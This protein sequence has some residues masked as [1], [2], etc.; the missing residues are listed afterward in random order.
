MWYQILPL[1]ERIVLDAAVGDAIVP[2]S[3]DAQDPALDLSSANLS[4]TPDLLIETESDITYFGQTPLY[5]DATDTFLGINGNEP[6]NPI[7]I[8]GVNPIDG[9]TITILDPEAGDQLVLTNPDLLSIFGITQLPITFSTESQYLGVYESN[10]GLAGTELIGLN[11]YTQTLLLETVSPPPFGIGIDT[12]LNTEIVWTSSTGMNG[13]LIYDITFESATDGTPLSLR[14]ADVVDV[15]GRIYYESTVDGLRHIDFAATDTAG[16]T[17][18]FSLIGIEFQSPNSPPNAQD[19]SLSTGEDLPVAFSAADLLGNDSDP[20]GDD[21][22]IIKLTNN[23]PVGSDPLMPIGGGGDD[24]L[25]LS[26]GGNGFITVNGDGT[27]VYTPFQGF[28]GTDFFVYTVSDGNGGEATATVTVDVAPDDVPAAIDVDTV[29]A[30][31]PVGGNDLVTI[32]LVSGE[33]A[34][35]L[36]NLDLSAED[37][38]KLGILGINNPENVLTIF[39][40]RPQNNIKSITIV[41]PNPEAGDSLGFLDLDLISDTPVENVQGIQ[42]LAQALNAP[43]NLFGSQVNLTES[44]GPQGEIIYT[45]DFTFL[46]AGVPSGP[47]VVTPE[48]ASDILSLVAFTPEANSGGRALEVFVTDD[49]N[50]D[51]EINIINILPP[52]SAPDAQDDQLVLNEDGAASIDLLANDND[53]DLDDLAVT[54]VSGPAN[55]QAVLD[56]MGNLTYTPDAN[57]NGSDQILYEIS[58]GELT[59]QATLAITVNPV[60]DAP[61]AVADA[62]TVSAGLEGS[63]NVLEN[64]VDV[65]LPNDSLVAE[66]VSGPQNGSLVFN[67]DGSFVYQHD[68]SPNMTDSFTYRVVD[69]A[70]ASDEAVVSLTIEEQ[71]DGPKLKL[72]GFDKRLYFENQ[73]AKILS[74][75]VFLRDADS[76]DFD[77]GRLTVDISE[78]GTIND[79]LLI[80]ENNK[81]W[82]DNAGQV[83]YR[84]E[85]IGQVEGGQNGE[86]LIV[87]F[88]ANASAWDVARVISRIAY[89]N[90]SD[91]PDTAVRNIAFTVSDGDGGISNLESKQIWFIDINDDPEILSENDS[92]T[93]EAGELLNIGEELGI[94]VTDADLD[95]DGNVLVTLRVG[96]GLLGFTDVEDLETVVFTDELDSDGMRRITFTANLDEANTLLSRLTYQARDNFTGTDTLFVKVNDLGGDGLLGGTGV[97]WERF[98]IHVC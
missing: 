60:N 6:D 33:E 74:P 56:A 49:D 97:D 34:T 93:V 45:I 47:T 98:E 84:G 25:F 62:L 7:P 52:N 42:A 77:G 8:P 3:V 96:K 66:L 53:P 65:D 15:L 63:G 39:S 82:V 24:N 9:L 1:E 27:F 22:Q 2:D 92:A 26:D 61:I 31:N 21:L 23:D 76:R 55:G 81:V 86:A 57:Y 72:L 58:D 85:V 78:N 19:D 67:A 87:D 4:V 13:E 75:A 94:Q 20:D 18:S 46:L 69:A 88:N 50:L 16:V 44:V 17:T 14:Q 70:G 89:Q 32:S 41:N 73:G 54:I 90:D 35:A 30:G 43:G 38:E 12:V 36:G 95:E 64:D 80:K 29:D 28:E 59:D 5:V 10:P 11:Q 91:N 83:L 37:Q 48:Q 51:S 68:G 71:S 40:D 79:Q